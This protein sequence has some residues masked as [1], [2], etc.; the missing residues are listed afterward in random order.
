MGDG[1]LERQIRKEVE[2][3]MIE[4][5]N[6]NVDKMSKNEN[7]YLLGLNPRDVVKLVLWIE[8]KY[9][10]HFT[11]TEL[12]ENKFDSIADVIFAIKQHLNK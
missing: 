9:N 7:F 6:V 1:C 3:F 11:E 5:F 12:V 4:Q 10:I 2:T 8:N